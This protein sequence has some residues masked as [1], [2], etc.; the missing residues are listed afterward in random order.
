MLANVKV[1]TV[2]STS[3]SYFCR[4]FQMMTGDSP[5]DRG[6]IKKLKKNKN[7]AIFSL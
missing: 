7:G 2:I 6:L 5:G 3:F 4:R 1:S